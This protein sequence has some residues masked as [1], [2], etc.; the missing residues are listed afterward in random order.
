MT[1]ETDVS[2]ATSAGPAPNSTNKSA[3]ESNL[4]LVVVQLMKGVVYQDS[5]PDV[6]NQLRKLG[7][8]VRDFAG[9][10][11]LTVSV[12]EA[13]GYAFLRSAPETD[14]GPPI[15]RLVA[16]RS[17]SFHLSLLLALLRKRLAEHDATDSDTRLVLTRDQMVE[18]IRVFMP[19]TSNDARLVDQVDTQIRKASNELGFLRPV[20]NQD[21]TYEVRRILKAFVDGQWLADFDQRLA[22]YCGQLTNDADA[23]GR[24]DADEGGE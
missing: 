24:P 21:A 19:D 5:H 3:P 22:D 12:D 18:M 2:R 15:P 23:S 8:Q 17:L 4:S 10:M 13:E 1:I 7:P 9:V 14:E 11:G 6:W 16:R 20:K